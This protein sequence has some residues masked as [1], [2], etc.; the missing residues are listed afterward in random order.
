MNLKTTEGSGCNLE[1]NSVE[2]GHEEEI[3]MP[4]PKEK[5]DHKA[6]YERRKDRDKTFSVQAPLDLIADFDAKIALEPLTEDGKKVTRNG[7]I[8][9]WIEEYIYGAK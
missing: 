8:R 3:F 2:L 7:L 6:E 1:K 5:R 9:K 4:V